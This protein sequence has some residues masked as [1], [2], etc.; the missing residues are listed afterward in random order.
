M[1]T[2]SFL[3]LSTRRLVAFLVLTLPIKL[4][5][6]DTLLG[7]VGSIVVRD[8]FSFVLALAMRAIYE[9]IYRDHK[10]PAWIIGSVVV[11]SLTAALLQLPVFYLLGDIFPFEEKT[12]FSQSVALGI[13][14]YRTG[15]FMCWSLLYF[16]IKFFRDSIQR[17][18][19]LSRAKVAR[20]RA[21]LQM[22][23]AQMNPHFL[24]NALATIRAGLARPGPPLKD[25][26]QALADYLRYSL[27]HR[28]EDFVPLGKEFDA[29]AAYLAVEKARFREEME[30]ACRIDKS[31]RT[32][33]CPGIL[34]QPLVENAIKYG[35]Q[36]SPLTAMTT[37]ELFR[38]Y[39]ITVNLYPQNVRREISR[40]EKSLE[41]VRG[42][43]AA[44]GKHSL[45]TSKAVKEE[46]IK[47]LAYPSRRG[48]FSPNIGR[49]LF[50]SMKLKRLTITSGISFLQM[51]ESPESRWPII[52][53]TTFPVFTSSGPA[54][55]VRSNSTSDPVDVPW[56]K[57]RCSRQKFLRRYSSKF[58]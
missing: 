25:V 5:L 4:I 15:L 7:M 53:P 50:S 47:H 29:V 39:S 46:R 27:E 41:R 26:V 36:T 52:E 56:V 49:V 28:T 16:G 30:M 17:D 48:R 31:A 22:L 20:Q 23:R 11:A 6:S 35:R 55:L 33:S 38:T 24:F 13:F 19:S 1:P 34:L 8:G 58:R 3:A 9:R 21:E 12:L 45:L 32:A 40:A 14:Y 44:E 51:L 2:A 57:S 10:Q 37:N 43:Y 42:D 54:T 18:L